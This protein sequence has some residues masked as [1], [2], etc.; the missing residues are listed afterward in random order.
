ML[1][2]QLSRSI[3]TDEQAAGKEGQNMEK[4]GLVIEG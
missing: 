2:R 3:V 1:Y 4:A